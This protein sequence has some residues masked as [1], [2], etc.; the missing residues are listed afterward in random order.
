MIFSW[1][2]KHSGLYQSLESRLRDEQAAHD[3]TRRDRDDFRDRFIRQCEYAA[4]M[5]GNAR[6]AYTEKPHEPK[7]PTS[8]KRTL[9][10]VMAER[11]AQEKVRFLQFIN[12]NPVE[13]A[14]LADADPSVMEYIK[15]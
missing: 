13:K 4:V 8:E 10:Q 14:K 2:I 9:A 7:P 12:D 5:N 1:L 11:D 6:F 15:H 3:Q